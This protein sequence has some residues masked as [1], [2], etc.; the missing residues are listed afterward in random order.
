L[1]KVYIETYGCALNK[2][3]SLVMKRILVEN[4]YEIVE[5]V[6]EA[7][8]VILNTCVV[9]YDT[10]VRMFKRIEQLVK[11]G[12]KLIVSGCL[13]RVYP[14]K[15][16]ALDSSISMISPQSIDKIVTAIESVNTVYLYD[17]FKSF[18]V[19]PEIVEGVKATIPVAE[20]CLDECS[21]C[22]VKI[23]RPHLRSV[24]IERVVEGVK[25]VLDKGA[26]EIEITAQDLSVY[27]YDLYGKYV[28]PELLERILELEREGFIIRLGQMNP[29]HLVFYLDDLI[30]IL[31]DKRVYKH[32]HIPVQSGSNKVLEYMNRKHSIELFIDIVK[33]LRSKVEGIHI[34]TDIIV[35]HPGEEE[36]DFVKSVEL[37]TMYGIDRV[38]IARFSPRPQTK[39]SLMPQIPDPVKKMRSSYIE[40]IYEAVALSINLEY[41]GSVAKVWIT[42]IDKSRG[43]AVGRLFNYRPVV[44]DV[45][46]EALGKQ[47]YIKIENATFY[48]LRGKVLSYI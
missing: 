4:G 25:K 13:T 37:I 27:G 24:P 28:L 26:I 30:E 9:R 36:E 15:V 43:R 44:L 16:K 21:F 5:S 39:S 18:N 41:V 14:Y 8:V 42:E 20:G 1:V 23:A 47:A 35:G 10:E 32:V 7:D 11:I 40:K 19:L 46:V 17:E 33:E 22:V 34:A 29:R 3:D 38:H 48:D 12:K 45:G 6:E 2:A 31:K